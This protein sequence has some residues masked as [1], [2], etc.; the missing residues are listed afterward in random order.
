MLYT[1]VRE[2]HPNPGRAP[3]GSTEDLGWSHESGN[4]RSVGERAQRARW[5]ADDYNLSFPW[6]I[7][8]MDDTIFSDYW[9]F[10]FYVGWFIDCDG[11]VL[12]NEPWGWATPFTQWCDLP[13]ADFDDL[14][15]TIDAYLASPPP[16]YR[17][18]EPKRSVSV[19]P[20]VAHVRGT[21]GSNWVTDLSIGNPGEEEASVEIH[22]QPWDLENTD[23]ETIDLTL[24]AG[25]SIEYTDVLNRVFGARGAATLRVESNRPVV[26]VSRTFNETPGGSFGQF[27]RALPE[28][29]ALGEQVVGHLLMLEESSKFRTNIGLVNIGDREIEAEIELFSAAGAS[30]GT[31][32]ATVPA[33]GGTQKDRIIRNFTTSDVKGVRAAVRVLTPGGRGLAYASVI[34]NDTNDPTSIEP[35]VSPFQQELSLAAAAKVQGA[36]SSNWVT[37]IFISNLERSPVTAMVDRWQRDHDG[38]GPETT[39][40]TLAPGQSLLVRDVLGSLF[41]AN[42]AAALTVRGSRGLMAAGR[43]YNDTSS[44]S[45]GHFL[46]GLDVTGDSL[47][48]SFQVGHLLQ[49]EE[50]GAD[51]RRTNIGLVNT[52]VLPLE[53]EL[54]LLNEEGSVLGIINQNLVPNGF[55]QLD[56][57]LRSVSS[58]FHRNARA[59]IRLK[60]PVGAVVAYATSIDNRTGDPVMQLAWPVEEPGDQR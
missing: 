41:A 1:Y 21:A 53:I 22:L 47:L 45:F 11:T 36:N 39:E 40:L 59:E 6:I 50:S 16:C 13:L 37:D 38:G 42:G 17:G 27:M 56:R 48:R 52:T 20:A 19:V 54:T 30:L 24:A 10:G 46:P 28:D 8:D 3:C 18:V 34:D 55:V 60:S 57:V 14:E 49:L 51:G 35:I 23:P 12:L 5:L 32:V 4:T 33:R 26:T 44:G 9:P 15:A 43:T 58:S 2:A 7:D 31:M 25:A 29:F